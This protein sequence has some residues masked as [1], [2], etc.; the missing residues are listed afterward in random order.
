MRTK[1][2]KNK[3]SE[4]GFYFETYNNQKTYNNQICIYSD[5][6]LNKTVAS[7]YTEV[8]FSIDLTYGGF[9]KLEHEQKEELFNLIVEY[10]RTPVEEREEPKKYYLK[11]KWLTDNGGSYNCLNFYV[12]EN[13]YSIESDSD[14]YGFKTQFT[15]TEIDE[16]K[17]RFNTSLE[18]FEIIEVEE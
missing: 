12:D 14:M 2:F 11:H 17:K 4:L 16:I 10:A 15:Q 5:F 8:C 3:I 1:E 6:K 18:D 7:V 9:D 13:K